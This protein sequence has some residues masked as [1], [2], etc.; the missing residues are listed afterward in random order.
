MV[1]G[2]KKIPDTMT[3]PDVPLN[4]DG[5]II[6]Q[7]DS[8]KFLGIFIDNQ[9]WSVHID[10]IALKI[11]KGLGIIGKFHNVFPSNILLT[12]YFTLIYPYLLYCNIIWGCAGISIMKKLITAQKRAVRLITCSAFGAHSNVLF[13]QLGLLKVMDIYT[14]QICMFVFKFKHNLIPPY[15]RRF[16]Y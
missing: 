14:F 3:V 13:A 7:V 11:S 8:T 16:H 4:I 9:L 15:A 5:K 10:Y 1:F 6:M 2:R 12:L